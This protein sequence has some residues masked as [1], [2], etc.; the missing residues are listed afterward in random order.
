M[1][2]TVELETGWDQGE[3]RDPTDSECIACA[4]LE[5]RNT[6]QEIVKEL[7]DR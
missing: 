3:L 6:M 5:V 1:T 7:R 2:P 4:I